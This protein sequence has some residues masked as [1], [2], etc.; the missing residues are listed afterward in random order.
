MVQENFR[1]RDLHEQSCV[2]QRTTYHGE[3][4]VRRAA[5][6]L[7]GPNSGGGFVLASGVREALLDDHGPGTGT[8]VQALFRA[9]ARPPRVGRAQFLG[10][11]VACRST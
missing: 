5:R 10:T 11:M 3:A 2:S 4:T 9:E 7:A 6:P 8:K 1:L